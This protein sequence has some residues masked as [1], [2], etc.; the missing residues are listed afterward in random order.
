MIAIP[1]PALLFDIKALHA[2]L[3]N[4]A[5]NIKLEIRRLAPRDRV[6]HLL[7][8]DEAELAI[9]V[10]GFQYPA[11]LNFC[12]YGSESISV[13]Y[14][15]EHRPPVTTVEDYAN[16][17]H[18][19][20][21]FGGGVKSEVERKL[22]E[23]GVRREIALVAPTASM[24][25]DLIKGTDIIATM[26][27]RL[28][29][30]AYKDLARCAPPVSFPDINYDLVW[31]RR[32][33]NSG[34]NTWLRR[35]VMDSRQVYEPHDGIELHGPKGI[36]QMTRTALVT[37]GGSGVGRACATILAEAGYAV[38]VAGR[39]QDTL[40]KT[41]SGISNGLAI[42]CDVSIPDQVDALFSKIVDEYGHLDVLFNN[43]GTN[44]GSAPIGDIAPEDFHQSRQCKPRRRLPVRTRCIQCHAGPR[45]A[46]GPHYQQRFDF[47]VGSQTRFGS[48][49]KLETRR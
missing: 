23:L 13:F 30:V 19:T 18:G 28:G 20:V 5:P 3:L 12:S 32:Y 39:N 45:T 16:A 44:V 11:T 8:A 1:T 27:S 22:L 9:S 15:A 38:I 2:S 41:M 24:L 33:E 40:D 43:A 48:L 29:E 25:G 17:R 36:K 26:P 21:N 35:L 46:G 34:R 42:T 7:S 14:D 4:A 49:H 10:S 31:H 47:R 37:G 6:T